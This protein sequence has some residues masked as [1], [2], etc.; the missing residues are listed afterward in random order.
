MGELTMRSYTVLQSEEAFDLY[1]EAARRDRPLELDLL[2][3]G[4]ACQIRFRPDTVV[5]DPDDWRIL[6]RLE[7]GSPV[8]IVLGR[9]PDGTPF[10]ER[11]IIVRRPGPRPE[12]PC[13]GE[14]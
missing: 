14:G 7:D 1:A 12:E 13:E 2:G 3:H 6:G 5:H 9:R 11:A 8:N 4:Q 10:A